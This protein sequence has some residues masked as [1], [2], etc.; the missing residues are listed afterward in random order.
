[1]EHARAQEYAD[2]LLDALASEE[3]PQTI[4]IR[5]RQ[6][7]EQIYKELLADTQQSFNGLFARMQYYH[8]SQD[9]PPEI[10]SQVNRL[11]LMAN[12]AAHGELERGSSADVM[13]GALCIYRLL[14]HVSAGFEP[15]S[16]KDALHDAKAFPEKA[17][18][19]KRSFSGLLRDWKPYLS[20]GQVRG[21][22]LE[23]ITEDGVSV[24]ILLRDD[25]RNPGKAKFSTM[26]ASFWK[27][28]NL[29]C[30]QLSEVAGKPDFYI[31]NP[32]SLVVLE[33][34][35]LVDASSIAECMDEAQSHPELYIL[36]RLFSEP[37]AEKMM[38]GVAVN[39]MFDELVHDPQRDYLELFKEA[40]KAMCIPM[41]SLG[42]STAMSIYQDIQDKHLPVLKDACQQFREHELLLEPSFLCPSFGLQGRLDL[43]YYRK[44]KFS[45]VELKSGKAHSHDVWPSQKYQ[46]VAY[47]MIIRNAYGSSRLGSSCILYSA[48]REKPLRDIANMPLLEQNL[49]HCRNRIVGIMRLLSTEPRRFFDWLAKQNGEGYSSFSKVKLERLKRMKLGLR[50]FEYE[51][52]LE[53]IKRVAREIWQV[54]IGSDSS[55][56]SFGHNALWRLGRAE[57]EGKIIGDLK[58][59]DYDKRR[60]NLEITQD[61]GTTD[62][63]IGDIV[64]LYQQERRVDQQEVIRGTIEEIS[65]Q[66]ISLRMRGGMRRKLA[67]DALWSIEHDVIE[68]FLYSPLSSLTPFLEAPEDRRDLFFG[69]REPRLEGCEDFSDEKERVLGR[70]RAA[71]ELFL[72]QG[73]PGTGKTSGLIGSY[74]ENFFRNTERKML[75]LSFTNRAVDEICLCL[76]ERGVPFLRTGNSQTIL[77]ELLDTRVGGKRFKE[78]DSLLRGTRIFVATVQSAKSW[79]QDLLRFTQIDEMIIDEA[80]QILESSILGLVNLA[81]KCIFIGDQNQLPPIAVQSPLDFAFDTEPLSDL[82]YDSIS[83]SLMER[84]FRVYI[85]KGWQSHLAMLTGHYRMHEE[86]AKLISVHYDDK[87]VPRR[88]EQSQKLAEHPLPKYLQKRLLWIDCPPAEQDYFDPRQVAAVSSIVQQL[89]SSGAVK[90]PA[91]EIGV[92]APYRVMIHAL[93]VELPEITI[94]TVERF[95]GSERDIVIL[96]FPLR[97]FASLG[98][99]Q[100]LSPDGRV[101]RKLNV[102]IS[103]A[104]SR[105]IILANSE[106]SR[107]SPHYRRL[108]DQI[109][110]SGTIT[111]I[112]DITK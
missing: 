16:L 47:N 1:M 58:I 60:I 44:G 43:L 22:E 81:P 28:A 105:L 90:D 64:L 57:K 70:M 26:A 112:Q 17:P 93:R 89:T 82:H 21:L 68:G 86:I 107:Q 103:R 77:D 37:S 10:V 104:R 14:Q 61:P 73:P 5:Q 41:V 83:Q 19:R 108:Y 71:E 45:I 38:L 100:S 85:S 23:I 109:S 54:K 56:G 59:L 35:F 69:L 94:D 65:I 34:D 76:R 27:Y 12:K 101:D 106:I 84:L 67:S 31:D 92:V 3:K 4:L 98:S 46:V 62:F 39:S 30:H 6:I 33:P 48:D 55:A 51:W 66:G 78:I 111:N 13:S 80:S 75:V 88:D 87:L 8:D 32:H 15:V 110:S 102:A 53:M 91:T 29:Y 25:Q 24:R 9:S 74:V 96:S 99:L 79:H 11:R 95:Q 63:R 42:E 20:A 36:S 97:N 18:S 2:K 49:I 50:D 7:L 40:L 72:V 52:F